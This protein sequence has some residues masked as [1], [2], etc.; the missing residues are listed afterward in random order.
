VQ[1]DSY[2][3]R[4]SPASVT[5]APVAVIKSDDSAFV[6]RHGILASPDGRSQVI[7][8]PARL[9][10]DKAAVASL[11][12]DSRQAGAR[13]AQKLNAFSVPGSVDPN[14]GK[15]LPTEARAMMRGQFGAFFTK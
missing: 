14:T 15:T 2:I 8:S 11:P 10:A 12:S 9:G 7:A 5:T 13:A 3:G 6:M 1:A 4:H